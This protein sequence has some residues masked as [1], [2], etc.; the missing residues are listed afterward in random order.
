MDSPSLELSLS[1]LSSDNWMD[2]L[3]LVAGRGESALLV[4]APGLGEGHR[5]LLIGAEAVLWGSSL[6]VLI[7]GLIGRLL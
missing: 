6:G 5:S 2:L 7:F 3:T 1:S 4:G